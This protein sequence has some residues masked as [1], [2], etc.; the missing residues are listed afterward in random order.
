MEFLDVIIDASIR[1]SIGT[2]NSRRLRKDGMLPSV[3]YSKGIS[4][5]IMINSKVIMN[6]LKLMSNCIGI[7]KLRIGNDLNNVV[8]K[9][10]LKHPFKFTILHIDFQKIEEEDYLKIKVP[11]LFVGEKDSLGIRSGGI[12]MK[13]MVNLNISG[14]VKDIPNYLTI[15]V[16]QLNLNESIY[17]SDIIIPKGIKVILLNK[18]GNQKHLIV[19]VIVSKLSQLKVSDSKK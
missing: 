6:V 16:S 2:L 3:L 14:K 19:S 7:I 8:I 15:D 17:L 4:M 10:I 12:L 18:V 5:P 13:Q 1:D 9:N 11:F